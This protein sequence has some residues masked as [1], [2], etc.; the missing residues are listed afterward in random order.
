MAEFAVNQPIKTEE[1]KIEVTISEN[2]ALRPGRHRF[3]LVVA[4]DTGNA[5]QPDEVTVI[6]A[7]QTA[8]T[9][10]LSAPQTVAAGESFPLNGEKSFD[11]G[12]GRIVSYEWT[13]LGPVQG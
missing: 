7:D 6:V 2:N 5:S 9:A 12:G 4:D 10:V 11:L 1:P 3:R 8:P 13:Y